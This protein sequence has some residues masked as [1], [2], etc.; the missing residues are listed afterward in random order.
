MIQE[1]INKIS[2]RCKKCGEKMLQ[3]LFSISETAL[4]MG[5]KTIE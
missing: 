2:E 5:G 3:C 1:K 4:M